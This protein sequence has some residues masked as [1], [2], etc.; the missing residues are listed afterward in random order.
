MKKDIKGNYQYRMPSEIDINTII[1]RA[2]E[3]NA[4]LHSE[5]MGTEVYH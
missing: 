5:G 1:R 4:G 2:E 3:L